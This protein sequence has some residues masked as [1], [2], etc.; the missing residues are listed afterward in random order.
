MRRMQLS[1][2]QLKRLKGKSIR[3]MSVRGRQEIAR[4]SERAL[5]LSVGEM[6]DRAFLRHIKREQRGDTGET[7]AASIINRMR[8]SV[9]SASDSTQKPLIQSL[10]RR[11][12]IVALMQSRF[13]REQQAIIERADRAIEG[14]FDLLGFT[15]LD[16]GKPPDWLLEP[17]SGRRSSLDHWSRIDYLNP[18]V[19]GDKKI[20]WELNRHQH[21]VTLGQA[22]WLTRDERYAEA[23]VAQA[24]SWM[25]Q[26]P[27]NRGINWASS[28]ELAFRSI[29]WLWALHLF[30]DSRHLSSKF[31]LRLLKHLIAHGRHMESYLSYYFSP[32]THLTGEAL[33]LFYLGSVLDELRCA[34]RWRR[35]GLKVLL[36]ELPRQVR[37]DGVYFEQATYYHRYTADFYT[38]LLILARASGVGLP[39]EVEEKLAQLMTHLMWLTRPDGTSPLVGDDDGGR[40]IALGPREANDFRDTLATAAALFGRKDWKCAAGSAAVE[41]LWLLG[42]DAIARYDEVQCESPRATSHVFQASGYA[43]ARDGWSKQSS[44]LLMDSGPHGSLACG[45]AHADALSIEFAALGKVWIV[46][47]GTFTYTAD[48]RLRN[49]FRLTAA[50]NTVTVDGK[51]QSTPAGPF[52]WSHIAQ[53]KLDDFIIGDGFDYLEGHTDGYARLVDSVI[54]SRAV[55]MAKSDAREKALASIPTY[56]IIRDT[57]QANGR[58]QYSIRFHLAPNCSAFASGNRVIVTEPSGA[59]LNIV[60]FGSSTL[61][62]RICESWVSRAYGRREP[63]L[64]AVFDANGDGPQEFTTFVVPLAAEQSIRIEQPTSDRGGSSYQLTAGRMRDALMIGDGA[65]LASCGLLSAEGAFAW[66]R[67]DGD[68]FVRAFLI[69]GRRLETLDG[70]AFRATARVNHCAIRRTEDGV[71]GSIN[72]GDRFDLSLSEAARKVVINGAS[73][74]VSQRVA[75]FAGD[76]IKWNLINAS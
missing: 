48:S 46:D 4:L 5:G 24:S 60:A 56:L 44:Y 58:H 67:F 69:R 12:E 65:K 19:A 25:D 27:P 43:V 22:Y 63:S 2:A 41:T 62:A 21:F 74:D 75:A 52:S 55:L 51:S 45:H 8:E 57:L 23:F 30:A 33:G 32:N 16:F 31:A 42:P 7:V 71:E 29:A 20:T 61:R 73:F 66:A 49:R 53:A 28:L 68:A 17:V 26:N 36:D 1:V 59:R 54:H 18:A 38:H 6:S 70:F 47:P 40:L 34:E 10:S 14:R 3:E 15:D 72:G 64:V 11:E 35:L 76:G 50:H 9:A 37:S 39:A 13:A